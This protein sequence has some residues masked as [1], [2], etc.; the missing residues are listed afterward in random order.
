MLV[1]RV[2]FGARKLNGITMA[3]M[4]SERHRSLQM[5]FPSPPSQAVHALH[6][7][8]FLP[9]PVSIPQLIAL[10]DRFLLPSGPE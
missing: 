2:H 4:A 5:I 9:M 8:E 10:V 7:G 3:L 1:T 6:F